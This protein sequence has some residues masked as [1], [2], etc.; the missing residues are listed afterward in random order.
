VLTTMLTQTA[1]G[2]PP[3]HSGGCH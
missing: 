1:D 3:L 2:C